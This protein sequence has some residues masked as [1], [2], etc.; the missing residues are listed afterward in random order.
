MPRTPQNR[1]RRGGRSQHR[2]SARADSSFASPPLPMSREEMDQRGWD[3]LDIL[4]VS[5]DAYVDHPSFGVALL[6]RHLEAHGFRVGIVAQPRWDTPDDVLRMGRP[7]LF[8]GVAAGAMDSMLAHY[9][10]FRKKRSNDAYTP[11]GQAG[12]RPNRAT[13]VYTG[14]VRHAFPGLPVVIGGIEA[15]L[16]RITHYDFWSD[17]LRRSILL[18]SK[19]DLL[20]YGMGEYAILEVARRLQALPEGEAGPEALQGIAGT[21]FA[22]P[23]REALTNASWAPADADLIEL[24]SHEEILAEKTKLMEATL[25]L[26]QHV[27][28]GVQWAVQDYSGRQVVLAPPAPL[29]DTAALD[30]LYSLP[31]TRRPHP[32]YTEPIPAADMIQFSMTAHRGCAGGCTFCSITLHQGRQIRSRSADSLER[33]VET[34]TGH[35]DWRGYISDVGGPTAN[36]WGARC[37]GDHTTCRR[38]D[39]LTPE[40]CAHFRTDER[41]MVEMLRTLKQH[42]GVKNIRVASGIRYDLAKDGGTHLRTLVREFVGGQLKV[43]PEHSCDRVLLLMR[44]PPFG[45]FEAF[46]QLFSRESQRAGKEQYIIPYLISA[47]PGCTAKDMHALAHWLRKQGWKPRQVQCFIPTPGTV[48]T[49]MYYAGIDT[50]GAPIYV[51]RSDRDRLQQHRILIPT[52]TP[53]PERKGN[54]HQKR[55]A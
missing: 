17:K 41:Q 55:G 48:A 45:Q 22:M 37:T 53:P 47:F 8:A 38:S 49:A 52:G 46:L 11:G 13:I 7:R 20:V 51:A 30:A 4:L 5:G 31:F 3:A 19:A 50:G 32:A 35:P 36:M 23:S 21:V 39:C 54:P 28:Q 16:R 10:A 25:A 34:L 29:L 27:H 24:P 33:E 40:T 14:L 44:K 12:A 15:S 6:G 9:T 42:K 43:A 26:E 1:D 2:K 18:D